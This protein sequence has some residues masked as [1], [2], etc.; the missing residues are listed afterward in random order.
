MNVCH[1]CWIRQSKLLP[2]NFNSSADLTNCCSSKADPSDSVQAYKDMWAK[3]HIKV[4]SELT[5]IK[6]TRWNFCSPRW[7]SASSLMTS[8]HLKTWRGLPKL[9]CSFP[10]WILSSSRPLHHRWQHDSDS[11]SGCQV[12]WCDVTQ[13]VQALIISNL[14]YCNSPLAGLPKPSLQPQ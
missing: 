7:H 10:M 9:C 13:H 3:C 12:S 11:W 14:E 5:L 6:L 4:D 1:F 8:H 2:V